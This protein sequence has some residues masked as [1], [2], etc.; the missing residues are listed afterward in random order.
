MPQIDIFGTFHIDRPEKV[1]RE[2]SEFSNEVDVFFSEEARV[3]TELSEHELLLRNPTFWF[4]GI[5]VDLFWGIPGFLLT[6]QFDPVDAVIT[7]EVAKEQNICIKPVDAHLAG[8][9]TNIPLVLT[10]ASWLWFL[11]TVSV[12]IFGLSLWSK[13]VLLFGI[14]L[15]T[16]FF[17]TLAIAIGFLPVV[18]FAYYSLSDRDSKM[19]ENIESILNDS[20]DLNRGCLIVGHKHINGVVEELEDSS[21]RV[22]KVYKP[23]FFRRNS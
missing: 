18:P 4:V 21:I 17:A 10:V 8:R 16:R 1:K 19:A 6:R 11:M 23:K 5:L 3:D 15:S 22:G 2:L 14:P 7:D 9:L 20:D 12:F 13:S